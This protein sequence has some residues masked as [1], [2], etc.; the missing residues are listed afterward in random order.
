M[1]IKLT[2]PQY[3]VMALTALVAVASLAFTLKYFARAFPE[4]SLELR[5]NRDE[6]ARRAQQF[7]AARGF[8]LEGYRHA[9]VFTYDD[10][11]KLYLE[12]TQG[13][14]RMNQL[15]RGPVRLWRWSHR[16]FRP[17][18]KEEF[19]ADVTPAGE[20]A[21]FAH[22]TAEDAPGANL[23]SLVARTIAE[24]FLRDALK[25]NLDDLELLDMESTKRPA[26]TDHFFTWKLKSVNLGDGSLRLEVEVDGN[27]VAAYREFIKVPEQWTR[28]YQQLRS[29]NNAAQ[30][31]DEV[32]WLVL[33]VVMLANL[34]MRLRDRD[35][36]LRLCA[37]LGVTAAVLYFLSQ[38]NTF[39]LAEYSYPTTSSYA[40]FVVSY[41]RDGLLSALGVGVGIFLVVAA[42]EPA[43]REGLPHLM[44]L[45][46][47]FTWQGL[48]TRSFFMANVVGLGL[49]FFFFAYQVG[50]YLTANR[51]GAWAPSD[52]NFSDELNTRIPWVAVLFGGFLPAVLE[53]M[54][55]R[56]FAVPFLKKITRS[57]ALAV[58]L[59]AFNWGFLH[60]AYPN[61]PFFI[62]GVEV[63]LGGII[64]GAV[65]LRFGILATLIWHYSVDALYTAFL[66]LRSHNSYLVLSGG[67][68]AGIMLIPLLLAAVA[69]WRSGTF[70]EE[71]GL[72]NASVGVVRAPRAEAV[73]GTAT[74]PA[75]E[76]LPR[77]RVA[78]AFILIAV[79]ISTALIPV[80]RFGQGLRVRMTRS[81]ALRLARA[82]LIAQHVPAASYHS[83]AWLQENVDARALQYLVE[84]RSLA[85][86]DQI[87]RQATRPLVW[88]VR[89]FRPLQKEE[90]LVFLDAAQGEVVDE[91]HVMDEAAPGASL[92]PDQARHLAEQ[93]LIRRGYSPDHFDLQE[94]ESEKRKA[95]QDY[96]LVWQAKPGDPRNVAGAYYWLEVNIA[97]DQVVGFTRTFKLPE[98]WIRHYESTRLANA[99]LLGIRLLLGGGIFGGLI[100]LLVRQVRRGSIR[101]RASLVVGA[102]TAVLFALTEL[103]ALPIADQRYDTS[104]PLAT[105]RL[106]ESIS[107][108]VV[109][110]LAGL[111]IVLLV[112]LATSLYPDA[113]QV[114]RGAARHLWRRD[115]AMATAVGLAAGFGTSRLGALLHARY[116]AYGV[117]SALNASLYNPAWP[118]LTIW[119][120]ALL[121]A[122]S[123]AAGLALVIWAVRRGWEQRS[124]WFWT[125]VT[126]LLVSLGPYRAH[127]L[128]EYGFGLALALVSLAIAALVLAVFFRSNAL[129]YVMAAFVL[130]LAGPIAR[131]VETPSGFFRWNGVAA[132]SLAIVTLGW[133]LS[134]SQEKTA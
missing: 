117:P 66:L 34:L 11:A 8:H 21:G 30:I 36:P 133:L 60:S 108:L 52:V 62:R 9:A 17:Q 15:T 68:T 71:A 40:S 103:N 5:V 122:I 69:Y 46:S 24:S 101:W 22:E 53:E 100:V 92:T 7:L 23:D 126:L 80:Y 2:S 55:F 106:F 97:G 63:G 6:S 95:R 88:V 113:W 123:S 13:L 20:I 45:R 81:D 57:W 65:M 31:V 118:A 131:L 119:L 42:S 91:R 90:Y 73:K 79:F 32:F 35:V 134:G 87:Y 115:A 51:L 29:R 86:A 61:E 107:F 19:R 50:F 18:Q 83:V 99:I 56:A 121:A 64:I 105:F 59:S 85:Q 1:P 49:T 110:A 102:L 96:T 127:S 25:R 130:P 26:R 43:Y 14:E 41:F 94:S 74:L 3:R 129:A 111:L 27:Q 16:W 33:S 112:A 78:M 38:A 48:R 116:P 58:V 37:G 104:I 98:E 76:H 75:Y 114:L 128:R 89:Y 39:S 124:P 120:E 93:A 28:S 84:H 77:G 10:E 54:Q 67:L 44:S 47:Y 132:L 12:R 4:A 72:T 82:Y 125:G 109:S 70:L